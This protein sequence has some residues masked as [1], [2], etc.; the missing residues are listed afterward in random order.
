MW[1]SDQMIFFFKGTRKI[2]LTKTC[3]K[4]LQAGIKPE[5]LGKGQYM[6]YALNR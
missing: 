4:G 6:V 5:P 2:R 1:P 3:S